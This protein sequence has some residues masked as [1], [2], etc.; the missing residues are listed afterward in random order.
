MLITIPFYEWDEVVGK[1][2]RGEEEY[3]KRKLSEGMKIILM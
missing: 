2:E 3:L 1:G